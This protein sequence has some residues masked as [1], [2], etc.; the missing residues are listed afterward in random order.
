MLE[1]RFRNTVRKPTNSQAVKASGLT[2]DQCKCQM[3]TSQISHL[4]T[5]L[6]MTSQSLE[7]KHQE[8]RRPQCP[9]LLEMHDGLVVPVFWTCADIDILLLCLVGLCIRGQ[10]YRSFSKAAFGFMP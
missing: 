7:A 8:A 2:L 9:E 6:M 5:Q 4:L 10:A 1:P 3:H